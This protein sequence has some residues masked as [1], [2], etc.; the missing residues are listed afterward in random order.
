MKVVLIT[1]GIL[2][3]IVVI[4]LIGFVVVTTLFVGRVAQGL[5][6]STSSQCVVTQSEASDILGTPVNT[7]IA[8]PILGCQYAPTQ[9]T[10][11]SIVAHVQVRKATDNKSTDQLIQELRTSDPNASGSEGG[12][13]SI[14]GLGD[15]AECGDFGGSLAFLYFVKGN[16]VVG[17]FVTGGD[18]ATCATAEKF[19]RKALSRV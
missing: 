13:H 6:D 5:K 7:P 19:A 8:I 1:C 10:A 18:N 11:S 2:A 17:V 12:T 9:S 15:K 3:G 16:T 14:S 4:V